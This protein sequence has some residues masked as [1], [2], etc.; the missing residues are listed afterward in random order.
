MR[1]VYF[2]KIVGVSLFMGMGA[3]LTGSAFITVVEHLTGEP[4]DGKPVK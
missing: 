1:F 2:T 3:L 4:F